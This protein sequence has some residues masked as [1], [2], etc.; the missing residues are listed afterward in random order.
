[1][2]D[3][4][5]ESIDQFHDNGIYLPTRTIRISG[6]VGES[7]LD[8]LLVNLHALDSRTGTINLFITSIGGE[9]DAGLAIYDAIKGCRNYVRG[10]VYGECSSAASYILQACDERMMSPHSYLMI[11][12]G[13]EGGG[14]SM[15][16]HNKERWDEWNAIQGKK[17]EDIYLKKI[18]E[19]KKRFT[20]KQLQELLKFDTILP[21]KEAIELGL[22]DSICE[23]FEVK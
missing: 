7:M 21:A 9:V 4:I 11:H 5:K 1:M 6:E 14:E 12:I 3:K 18:K 10:M 22:V 15:H 19:K 2:T 23:Q 20:R 8:S 16:V 13:S 17:M